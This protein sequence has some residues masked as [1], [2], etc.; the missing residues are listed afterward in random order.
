[1]STPV[2]IPGVTPYMSPQ[3][4]GNPYIKP[5][6]QGPSI[7][8]GPVPLQGP[9]QSGGV[10][11][12]NNTVIPRANVR[13][14]VLGS[15]TQ[16]TTPAPTPA[17]TQNTGGGGGG[18]GG[19][20]RPTSEAEALARGL[21][22][23]QFGGGGGGGEASGPDYSAMRNQI[24]SGFGSL[25]S[26]FDNLR[27]QFSGFQNEDISRLGDQAR[28]LKDAASQAYNNNRA[29]LDTYRGDVDTRAQGSMQSLAEQM[30]NSLR[31]GNMMLG[32]R[33]A[34]DSSA[35]DMYK[36]AISKQANRGNAEIARGRDAQMGELDRKALDLDTLNQQR[37]SEVDTW[38]F[39][40]ERQVKD[41]AR[42]VLMRIE[43]AKIGANQSKMQALLQL[44]QGILNQAQNELSML[45]QEASQKRMMAFQQS[46][47]Q[48]Q[49]M[50]DM[51]GFNNAGRFNVQDMQY[52][53]IDASLRGGGAGPNNAAQT[54]VGNPFA[55]KLDE[56]QQKGVDYLN[57]QIN[58]YGIFNR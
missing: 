32:A 40:S 29:Q 41:N 22:W 25:L 4:G 31:A 30:R 28:S 36:Y 44:E 57:S 35:S 56:G 53:P 42:D 21:D 51:S 26:Q 16:R 55:Q 12:S 6:A 17:P 19:F 38:Q 50:Q 1:M 52:S 48:Q 33:G 7:G 15:S 46:M 27:N 37:M 13:T 3:Y 11:F 8:S 23:N 58:R 39:D 14:D 5:G 43:N 9:T 24:E 45:Q 54:F 49:A 47:Q 18:G 2:P 10:L 20:A 34:S